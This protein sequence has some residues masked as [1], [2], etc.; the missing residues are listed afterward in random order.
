MWLDDEDSELDN[1][2]D[3]VNPESFQQS[4]NG[5]GE[6]AKDDTEPHEEVKGQIIKQAATLIIVGVVIAIVAI[7]LR[8]WI[9]DFKI[10]SKEPKKNPTPSTSQ[11]PSANTNYTDSKN[12]G[13]SWRAFDVD[14]EIEFVADKVKCSFTITNIAHQVRVVPN[15]DEIQVKSILTGNLSGFTGSYQLEVPYSKGC[16][17]SIGKTFDVEV[18]IGKRENF[19]VIGTITY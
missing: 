13:T 15:T 16:H 7:L 8:G 14:E 19:V 6:F 4:D 3:G 1:F 12:S 5:F 11:N 17:L 2:D 10:K 18:E 9:K